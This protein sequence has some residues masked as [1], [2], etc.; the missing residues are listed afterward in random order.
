VK[1][2]HD[3]LHDV[4]RLGLDTAP[5]IYFI[6]RNPTYI[7]RARLVFAM[8]DAGLITGYSSVITLTEVLTHPLQSNDHA[9]ASE[10]RSLLLGSQNLFLASITPAIAERAAVLRAQYRL[11]TP[12]ALQIA[13]AI[14]YDCDAFLTNDARLRRV[15][16]IRVLVF[17]DLGDIV[18]TS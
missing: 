12:D 8:I 18:P 17:D 14:E 10:Y 3:P 15:N 9:V 13:A 11:R 16:E 7:A 2:Q 4:Q 5:F 1:Q 6:E